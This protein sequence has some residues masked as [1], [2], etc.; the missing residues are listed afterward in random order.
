MN[1]KIRKAVMA[2]V[3][4]VLCTFILIGS[5]PSI[6]LASSSGVA[7]NSVYGADKTA[8][9]GYDGDDTSNPYGKGVDQNVLMTAENELWLYR[10]KYDG[11]KTITVSNRSVFDSVLSQSTVSNDSSMNKIYAAP[12]YD[13]VGNLQTNILYGSKFFERNTETV[14]DKLS[15]VKSV[16]FDPGRT[17]RKDYIAYLGIKETASNCEL[18]LVIEKISETSSGERH[19]YK[20]C[21]ANW[22][23]NSGEGIAHAKTGNYLS[24]TAGDYNGNGQETLAFFYGSDSDPGVCQFRY[25]IEDQTGTIFQNIAQ[26]HL[27]Y[28]GSTS[29]TAAAD[30]RNRLTCSLT[31][32]D[33]DGD[34]IDD[35]AISTGHNQRS[36]FTSTNY[37]TTGLHTI[38]DLVTVFTTPEQDGV[39][40]DILSK[41]A[42]YSLY[43][44]VDGNTYNAMLSAS[45]AAGDVDNDGVDEIVAAGFNSSLTYDGNK[46]NGLLS[47]DSELFDI[48][49]IDYVKGNMYNNNVG[50]S[51]QNMNDLM[52]DTQKIVYGYKDY[53]KPPLS[54]AC[55]TMNGDAAADT[56]FI[57]GTLYDLSGSTPSNLYTVPYLD[58]DVVT[59]SKDYYIDNITVGNFYGDYGREQFAY[60]LAGKPSDDNKY[61][62]FL[63]VTSADY[64]TDETTALEAVSKYIT[65]FNETN[66]VSVDDDLHENACGMNFVISSVDA[67]EDG[68]MARY[69]AKDYFYADP[70]ITAV[71]QAAPYFGDLGSY[72]D[73]DDG[74]TTYSV[75]TEYV[76]GNTK[77]NNVSFSAGFS[78][79]FSISKA[80]VSV[81]AGYALDWSESFE[82]EWATSYTTI[83]TAGSYDTVVI[84][85]IPLINYYYDVYDGVTKTWKDNALCV[86]V[87]TKPVFY[88]MS[89]DNYNLY[90]QEY[91]AEIDKASTNPKIKDKIGEYHRL[92]PIDGTVMPDG[93]EGNPSAYYRTWVQAG[94]GN[95]CLSA[96]RYQLS[97]NGGSTTSEWETKVSDTYSTETQHGFHFALSL[98]FGSDKNSAGGYVNLDYTHGSG[99][100]TT[101]TNE[102]GASGTVCG[103]DRGEMISEG[104]DGNLLSQYGFIWEFGTWKRMLMQGQPSVPIF[105]YVITDITVPGGN[106]I[107]DLGIRIPNM[108]GAQTILSWGTPEYSNVQL[109]GYRVYRW[110]FNNSERTLVSGDT[111]LNAS[112]LTFSDSGLNPGL[113]YSYCVAAVYNDP[114][115]GVTY[116]SIPSNTVSAVVSQS[117]EIEMRVNNNV[118]QWKYI[119]ESDASWRD[120]YTMPTVEQT[121]NIE[122]RSQNGVIQWRY[123][124]ESNWNDLYTMPGIEQ[125]DNIELR[126]ENGVVQWRYVGEGDEAWR[127][128]YTIPVAEQPENIELRNNAG[129]IQWRYVGEETWHDLY[130][131]P[132]TEKPDNV[133]LRT[134]NGVVQWR[135]VGEGNDAWRDLY[136]VPSAEQPD[137]IEL[138]TENGVLQWRY[139]GEGDDA[140]RDLYSLPVVNDNDN[141]F[142]RFINVF[143]RIFKAIMKI[144]ASLYK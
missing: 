111:L 123:V 26:G 119:D 4:S 69:S 75:S 72:G 129:I 18:W 95:Q 135:Y 63:C 76:Q 101:N 9:A 19:E 40:S 85:R 10:T 66:M 121:K 61:T 99:S 32:G 137:N 83:F 33:F 16:S 67:N 74:E 116:E 2:A 122:M 29:S 112:T 70:Q 88:Q 120:L 39:R 115:L 57:S 84:Q 144:I 127:E 138:R 7:E 58:N 43:S 50:I 130:T 22:M 36:N 141:A 89:V 102:N 100:Y 143:L 98:Q 82:K 38:T 107:K 103:I 23:S 94:E 48:C 125:P 110:D 44:K 62:Y 133:E 128:L 52:K 31:T 118:L 92:I 81:E 46:V 64:N 106:G 37:S 17:G 11:V 68:L 54:V 24:I 13:S 35:L 21:N 108:Y 6:T 15:Y 71:L 55:A 109:Q 3:A 142:E 126:A 14:L 59:G 140:W 114:I 30:E 139:V 5:L 91:N 131:M 77:S 117:N 80:K 97:L 27:T 49:C 56:V 34:N 96:S 25:N 105:G 12:E 65:I 87:P 47:Y 86:A 79:N 51:T 1:K 8:P 73:F 78:G 45:I 124:G 132:E 134:E 28:I 53:I 42:Q 41:T 104:Y 113:I 136:T 60:A 90:V 93:N 20:I